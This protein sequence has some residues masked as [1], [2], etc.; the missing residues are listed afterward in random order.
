[1]HMD[2]VSH[3]IRFT[4]RTI[5]A[6]KQPPPPKQVDYFDESLPGFG[7]R[8]SYGGRKSWTVLYRCN[9]IK[10]RLTIGRADIIPLADAR[11]QA[12][13]AMSAAARGQDPA[14]RN[15]RDREAPS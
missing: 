4:D 13:D 12:R 8:I 6:L 14:I 5:R 10:G 11:A 9:G 1:L 2:R 7:L 3:R 15:S